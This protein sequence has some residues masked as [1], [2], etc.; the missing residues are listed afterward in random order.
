[1][2]L[3]SIV[4]ASALVLGG[5]SAH[6]VTASLGTLTPLISSSGSLSFGGLINDN[7]TSTLSAASWLQSNVTISL[8]SAAIT[9]ATYGIYTAGLN[10]F[11]AETTKAQLNVNHR[12]QHVAGAD[13]VASDEVLAQLQFG[14]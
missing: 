14:F 11:F 12:V 4:F 13:D 2:K 1:M 8:G 10:V 5:V 3:K 7:Y 9:P 6:A